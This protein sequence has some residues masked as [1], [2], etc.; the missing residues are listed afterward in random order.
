M[1]AKPSLGNFCIALHAGSADSWGSRAQKES[2][3]L[4]FLQTIAQTAGDKLKA[5]ETALSVVQSVVG[6]LEDCPLFN[7]GKGS[8]LNEN[9][10]H[11]VRSP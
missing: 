4:E 2:E 7:A 9:G 6:A 8:V 3:I 10:A 5:D 11:E 1:A